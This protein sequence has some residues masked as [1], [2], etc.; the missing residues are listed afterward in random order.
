MVGAV[1]VIAN[2][3]GDYIKHLPIEVLIGATDTKSGAKATPEL[4]QTVNARLLF[5]SETNAEDVFNE[6][7][8]KNL[9][10]SS[11]ISVRS[12]YNSPFE[13][14]PQYLFAE[15]QYHY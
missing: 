11:A 13:F 6:G 4:A 12:L 3:V 10:G 9:T 2:V 5:T 1:G 8:I 7:K 14:V 15:T